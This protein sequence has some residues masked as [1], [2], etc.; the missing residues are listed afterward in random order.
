MRREHLSWTVEV[1]ASRERMW[2]WHV[3]PGAFERLAP[4][5]IPMRLRGGGAFPGPGGEVVFEARQAGI[6]LRWR[7]RIEEVEP[8]QRFVDTQLAGPFREWRH[9]HQFTSIPGG[10]TR[11]TDAVAYR[12][13]GL[14]PYVPFVAG[15]ARRQVERLFAFRHRLM[16]ADLMRFPEAPGGGR[17]VLVTGARGLVGRRLVPY[18][19]T[20]GYGVRELSR[21]PTRA[22]VY[23]WDPVA[24]KLDPAA[25]EGLHAV[26]HLAGEPIAGGR[27]TKTRME[28]IR[29]SR[30]EGTRFLIEQLGRH[31]IRP[32]A[33]ICASGVNYY[34]SGPGDKDESSPAGS[35]FLAEVCVAWEA[36][37]RRVEALGVRPV[38][39]RTGVVL[40]PQGGA[41][42]KMLP[43]FRLGLGG[44]IGGGRQH[45]PWIAVDDL[46]DVIAVAIGDAAMCG[47]VNAVHSEC[48]T[49]GQFSE[50][51]GAVLGRPAFLPMPAA[52]VRLLFGQMGQETLLADLPIRPEVLQRRG[53]SFRE[54][55]LE[56]SLRLLLGRVTPSWT[57]Y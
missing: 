52:A 27:W 1:A 7:A 28:A 39:L 31:G 20:L 30:V 13:P 38:L 19:K 42:A 12:L 11:L 16:R 56:A 5:W 41:L 43:A 55:H 23:H 10:G 4:R 40:D 48:L 18:L 21:G 2:E 45:F 15:H 32:D 14:L 24:R 34:G 25:L 22:G 6:W 47:P 36:A 8:Q 44:P 33:F 35:G 57:E 51:L 49:Q 54:Q 26:V 29:D 37:A 53:F 9:T 50:C 17:R 3:S 46:V